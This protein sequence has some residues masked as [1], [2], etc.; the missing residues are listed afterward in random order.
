MTQILGEK[1][2]MWAPKRWKYVSMGSVGPSYEYPPIGTVVRV[3]GCSG[4]Q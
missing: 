1:E 3:G 4:E 2:V